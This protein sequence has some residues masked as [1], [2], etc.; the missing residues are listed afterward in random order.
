MDHGT[1]CVTGSVATGTP[2]GALETMAGGTTVYVAAPDESA[3]K[4]ET[5]VVIATDVF[6]SDILF[7]KHSCSTLS[8]PTLYVVPGRAKPVLPGLNSIDSQD[9]PFQLA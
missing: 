8:H 9:H 3:A 5:A 4:P 2:S 7:L 6:G 1:C